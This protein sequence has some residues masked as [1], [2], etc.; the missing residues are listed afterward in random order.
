MKPDSNADSQIVRT[1]ALVHAIANAKRGVSL[2]QLADRRGWN[3]RAL[4][5]DI[6]A[7]KRAK[8]PIEHVHGKYSM[9]IDWL[10]P[11]MVG[12]ARDELLALFVA[13]H[14]SPGLQGTPFARS[15]DRLWAKLATKDGQVA[16]VPASQ[17][18]MGFRAGA[19]DYGAHEGTIRLLLD[20]IAKR[21]ALRIEYR[22]TSGETS[23][24][25]IEPGHVRWDGGLEAMYVLS[26][27]CE[28]K[29]VRVFAVQRITAIEMLDEVFVARTATS[30]Q[31]LDKSFRVWHRDHAS[32]VVLRFSQAV[33]GEIRE[34]TWHKS[35]QLKELKNGGLELRLLVSAPEELQRWLVG[36]GVDVE[37]VEP[38][39]LAQSV[40][41]IHLAAVGVER[42]ATLPSRAKKPRAQQRTKIE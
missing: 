29:A 20:G 15:L 9:P 7:L 13:R 27:C 33:A 17:S 23:T 4:Y 24:R 30:L 31:A 3:L 28:R 22:K 39:S 14:A 38:L 18:A 37:V 12:V 6:E 16:L 5:R 8:F 2:K 26:W 10:P 19:I 40:R 41:Q 1:L 34:R 32:P 35:Q 42:M 21:R 11:S 36:F 25:T